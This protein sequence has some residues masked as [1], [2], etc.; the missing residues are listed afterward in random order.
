MKAIPLF[1]SF[2]SLREA[3][4][5][6]LRIS[7][8]LLFRIIHRA[9]SC[10]LAAD[11]SRRFISYHSMMLSALCASFYWVAA[12][13]IVTQPCLSTRPFYL[14]SPL[15]FFISPAFISRTIQ[16]VRPLIG[17]LQIRSTPKLYL[18]IMNWQR[19]SLLESH[20]ERPWEPENVSR[21]VNP[22]NYSVP[23]GYELEE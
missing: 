23:E 2:L 22:R 21:A 9:L 11:S 19:Y 5:P 16:N 15:V 7:K 18:A 20:G 6:D 13:V 10:R 8:C 4:T 14:Y 3:C 12:E 1:S 17:T